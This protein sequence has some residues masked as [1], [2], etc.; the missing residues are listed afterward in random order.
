M[1]FAVFA[2]K[3]LTSITLCKSL[4]TFSAD[5]L[6][7]KRCISCPVVHRLLW[8]VSLDKWLKRLLCDPAVSFGLILEFKSNKRTGH[9]VYEKLLL[10]SF[11][12]LQF[13]PDVK[14]AFEDSGMN[15][16]PQQ[17]GT[18]LFVPIPK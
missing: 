14:K 6:E 9:L 10:S 12:K 7:Y 18:T 15:V 5:M 4:F 17:D 2:H 8:C 11:S 13:I 16:S 1:T 3:T